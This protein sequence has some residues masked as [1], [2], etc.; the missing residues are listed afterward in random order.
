MLYTTHLQHFD[1]HSTDVV[2][3]TVKSKTTFSILYHFMNQIYTKFKS[4]IIKKGVKFNRE[5]QVL[6]V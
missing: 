4:K 1:S 2:L 3:Q 6:K 5:D